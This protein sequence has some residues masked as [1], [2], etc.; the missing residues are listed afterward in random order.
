[1]KKTLWIEV[2]ETLTRN[3]GIEINDTDFTQ[4][5][6]DNLIRIGEDGDEFDCQSEEYN[7]LQGYLGHDNVSD[8]GGF[9]EVQIYIKSGKEVN[10]A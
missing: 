5:Q 2:K 7:I 6:A 4:E 8:S 10:H 1:M 3:I 9:E